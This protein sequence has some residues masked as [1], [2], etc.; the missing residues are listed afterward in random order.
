[1]KPAPGAKMKKEKEKVSEIHLK[2]QA[3]HGGSGL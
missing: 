2:E 1:L 3:R